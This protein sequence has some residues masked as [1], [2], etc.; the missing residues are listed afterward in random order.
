MAKLA[1]LLAPTIAAVVAT[2]AIA[3]AFNLVVAHTKLGHSYKV[4]Q[5]HSRQFIGFVDDLERTY[6]PIRFIGCYSRW[7]HVHHSLH[8]TGNA[9]DIEQH[10]WGRT[11]YRAMYHI[12]WLAHKHGL[13]DGCSF[14]DCGHVDTGGPLWAHGG[15]PGLVA[16]A[17]IPYT[18]VDVK[19][20]GRDLE[21]PKTLPIK[22]TASM[23]LAGTEKP[24]SKKPFHH[25]LKPREHWR[26]DDDDRRSP[27]RITYEKRQLQ[28]DAM[29]DKI[30]MLPGLRRRTG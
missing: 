8:H 6:G 18:P 30:R 23:Q 7:G 9:C 11:S 1:R 25:D 28:I 2:V 19:T 21:W 24:L 10:G 29:D 22:K 5:A 4:N 16:Q 26:Y 17:E 3:E 20:A 12:A 14:T 15:P 27:H 13:R